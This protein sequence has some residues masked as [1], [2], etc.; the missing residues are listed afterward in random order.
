MAT[1][2]IWQLRLK[3]RFAGQDCYNVFYYTQVDVG[4]P[5]ASDVATVVWE[6]IEAALR[7]LTT[8]NTTYESMTAINGMDNT[9]AFILP[10]SEA[11]TYPNA[12]GLPSFVALAARN[13][14]AIPGERYSYKRFVG[15]PAASIG[16]SQGQW[17]AA[18]TTLIETLVKT[19][20]DPVFTSF[21]STILPCQVTGGFKLGVVPTLGRLLTSP[22]QYNQI[23]SH[24]DTRQNLVW[25]TP[26]P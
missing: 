11:G 19:L 7:A 17:T 10:I 16:G 23:P 4:S 9:N 13:L 25:A 26:L 5:T 24:Q 22:W 8:S 21:G 20:D 3:S 18:Y 12:V 15:L 1:G 14:P 2:D 6:K